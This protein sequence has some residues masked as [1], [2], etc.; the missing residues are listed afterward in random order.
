MISRTLG[1]EFGGAIGSLFFLANV[2]GSGLA[3]TGCVEGLIQNLVKNGL[4]LPE[5]STG[6][7]EDGHW[8]RFGYCTIVNTLILVVVLIGAQMFAKTSAFILGI[9][10]VCLFSTY[11]SFITKGEMDV[12]IPPENTLLNRT[13]FP[14]GLHYTGLSMQTLQDNLYPSYGQDYTSGGSYVNFAIVFGVL[15]SGVTGIMAGKLI[16]GFI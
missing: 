1:P 10:V 6:L 13:E 4:L 9:V 2:V 3:I 7:L 8:Y 11:V 16:H 12:T 5:N 15:F 14:K